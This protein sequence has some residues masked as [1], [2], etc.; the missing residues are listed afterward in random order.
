MKQ[1]GTAFT[2]YRDDYEEEL[3]DRLKSDHPHKAVSGTGDVRHW[4]TE[5]VG[6][7]GG[8]ITRTVPT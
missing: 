7:P 3:P 6:D 2:M 4:I 1:Q 5:Y 8:T